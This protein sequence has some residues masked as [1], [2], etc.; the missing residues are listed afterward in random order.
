M[1]SE[2]KLISIFELQAIP[3]FDLNTIYNILPFVK[4]TGDIEDF[5]VPL[6]KLLIKGQHQIFLRY[7]QQF[8]HK[9][10]FT[11]KESASHFEGDPTK[12]YLRYKYNYSNKLSYGITAEKDAGEEFFKGNNKQG[13]D[14]YSGHLFF[15]TNTIFKKVALGDYQLKLG[16][17]LLIWTGFGTGKSS[18]TMNVKKTGSSI[19]PYTSVDEYRFFRGATT[20][21]EVG[22]LSITPFVSIKQVDANVSFSDSTEREIETL[23]LQTFG[24]HRI[25]N[26]IRQA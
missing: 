1:E 21:I 2:K 16:Q 9:K 23:S 20:E 22:N 24:L 13:F 18:F 8:P 25:K 4:V 12:L 6:G 17:G 10:G 5:H 14:F 11:D 19:K 26:I 7:T 3:S 15:K